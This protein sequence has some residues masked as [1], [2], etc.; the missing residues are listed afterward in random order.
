MHN[1]DGLQ[2]LQTTAGDCTDT[3]EQE[4]EAV[5]HTG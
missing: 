5:I 4:T 3:Q 1:T 2:Q